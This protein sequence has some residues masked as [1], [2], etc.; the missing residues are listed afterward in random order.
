MHQRGDRRERRVGILA[1]LPQTARAAAIR[2][3]Y[4][5]SDRVS[6]RAGIERFAGAPICPNKS[7]AN[8]RTPACGS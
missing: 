1:H 7:A 6:I 2:T 4:S 5:G 8:A 3:R